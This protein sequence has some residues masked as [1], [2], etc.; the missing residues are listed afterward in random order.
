MRTGTTRRSIGAVMLG[1]VLLCGAPAWA[2]EVGQP[3]P[4]F[5]LQDTGG[6]SRSLSEF[7]GKI[8][9]LEWVNPECPFVRKHYDSGNMQQLQ[10]EATGQDVVWLTINSSAEG[11]QGHLTAESGAEFLKAERASPTALLL[12]PQGTAGQAYGA[13]TT[14]HM[15]VVDPQG[16]LVYNG[17]IDSI[18]SVDPADIERSTNYVEQ[19]LAELREGKPVSTATSTPYGCSVKY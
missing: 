5:Q 14:P 3:A 15:F 12:D 18:R 2:A 1:A 4:D 10:R 7:A 17:A 9:V 16:V 19:A 6:Q 13:K 11:N 8:V